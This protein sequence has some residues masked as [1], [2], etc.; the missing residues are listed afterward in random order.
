MWDSAGARPVD[1][2]LDVTTGG[3]SLG[4]AT[5]IKG[6]LAFSEFATALEQSR[7]ALFFW[8]EFSWRGGILVFTARDDDPLHSPRLTIRMDLV[9][10][11]GCYV[12]VVE[13]T[14]SHVLTLFKVSTNY[15][16]RFD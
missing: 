12:L 11:E 10:V 15:A 4:I 5:L 9:A 16:D 2:K 1:L 13:R 7:A 14:I 8:G 3:L 6:D